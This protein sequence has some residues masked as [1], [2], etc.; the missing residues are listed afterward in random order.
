MVVLG[1]EPG[2]PVAGEDVLPELGQ[3]ELLR[4]LPVN[5]LLVGQGLGFPLFPRCLLFHEISRM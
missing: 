2:D 3:V 1:L 5:P 4:L